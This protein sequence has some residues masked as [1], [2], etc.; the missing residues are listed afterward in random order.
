[1]TILTHAYF[2]CFKSEYVTPFPAFPTG[3]GDR[4]PLVGNKKGGY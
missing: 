4:F 1:M 3:E 2:K